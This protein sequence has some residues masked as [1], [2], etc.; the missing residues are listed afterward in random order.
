MKLVEYLL[1]EN[2][3]GTVTIQYITIA[4]TGNAIDFGDMTHN[5]GTGAMGAASPTRGIIAGGSWR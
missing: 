3:I 4:A 1:V 5:D 2:Q